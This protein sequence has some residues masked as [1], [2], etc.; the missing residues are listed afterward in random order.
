MISLT[1][2]RPET[3]ECAEGIRKLLFQNLPVVLANPHEPQLSESE[4]QKISDKLKF[5]ADNEYRASFYLINLSVIV[6]NLSP[7]T[8]EKPTVLPHTIL[9]WAGRVGEKVKREAKKKSQVKKGRVIRSSDPF[10]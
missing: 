5:L 6:N 10:R 7:G 2:G 4:K 1:A 9:K 3:V 8:I